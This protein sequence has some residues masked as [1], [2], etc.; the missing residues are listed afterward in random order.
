MLN[1]LQYSKFLAYKFRNK[2]LLWGN[3]ES[4]PDYLYIVELIDYSQ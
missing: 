1:K 3:I 2:L 4:I